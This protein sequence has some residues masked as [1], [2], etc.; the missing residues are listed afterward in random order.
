[1]PVMITYNQAVEL[2]IANGQL[3]RVVKIQFPKNVIWTTEEDPFL[4]GASVR[5]QNPIHCTVPLSFNCIG[6]FCPA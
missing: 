5:V 2:G 1:M 3:G 4:D 6:P